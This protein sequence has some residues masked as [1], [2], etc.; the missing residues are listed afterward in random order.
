MMKT[1]KRF[2]TTIVSS[3]DWM[4]SQ[5]ENHEAL[6]DAAIRDVQQ[7]G[8]RAGVQLKRVK[9]DGIN[10][11]KRMQELRESA[12]VWK[13]RAQKSAD[14]DEKR[15]LECLKRRKRLEREIAALEE[16]ERGH[17]QVEKQL[18][19]D[20]K[21]IEE[22]L[23]VLKQQ[24]NVLRTRQSRAEALKTLHGDDSYLLTEIDGILERWES[25]VAEY[26]LQGECAV[27]GEDELEQEFLSKEEEE[28]LKE[29]LKEICGKEPQAA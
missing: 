20:L 8:A 5:V 22:R 19:A 17:A 26:E 6:V 2:A 11:R 29:E 9:Q 14:L 15:A 24:R 10:M 23:G 13:E 27:S 1:L 21:V 3:F 25:K 18:S 16:Q 7:A 28:E 4:I 12:E